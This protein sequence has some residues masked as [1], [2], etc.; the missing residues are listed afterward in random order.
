MY[1]NG[2]LLSNLTNYHDGDPW[3]V[4]ASRSDLPHDIEPEPPAHVIMTIGGVEPLDAQLG[5]FPKKTVPDTLYDTLFGQPDPIDIEV[6]AAGRDTPAAP[7]IRT[8]AIL[9]AA[10]F[11]NLPE[12]LAESD[13]EY[14]CM[15]KG[16]SFEELK[17]VAPWIVQLEEAS[18]FTRNLFTRSACRSGLGGDRPGF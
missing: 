16:D 4:E 7:P 2:L 13:L 12:L 6:E 17:E 18:G 15:F 3:I 10:K 8:Y 9:D 1:G 5:V 14:A 11:T